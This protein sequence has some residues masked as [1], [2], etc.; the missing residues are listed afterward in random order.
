[1][2]IQNEERKIMNI[3]GGLERVIFLFY[4]IAKEVEQMIY[5][6]KLNG[7]LHYIFPYDLWITSCYD[8][9][10]YSSVDLILLDSLR[11]DDWDSAQVELMR[12][13]K[14]C[15][16]MFH[17]SYAPK[18]SEKLKRSFLIVI[19]DEFISVVTKNISEDN[20]WILNST[21]KTNQ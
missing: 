6:M 14:Q 9:H 3:V 10:S 19:E 11:V 7:M 1:M 18:Q 4:L 20:A 8:F 12:L 17:Q 16:V 13:Q 2:S 15:K 5:S 21:F